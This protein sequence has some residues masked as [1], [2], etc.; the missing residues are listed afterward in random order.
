MAAA[1]FGYLDGVMFIEEPN[2]RVT[3][4]RCPGRM[5][6]EQD[7]LAGFFT[8]LENEYPPGSMILNIPIMTDFPRTR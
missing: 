1:G 4:V 2:L 5:S 3:A 6:I 7:V 8:W